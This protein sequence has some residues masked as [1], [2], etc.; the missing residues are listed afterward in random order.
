MLL[1]GERK[2]IKNSFVTL[3][4]IKKHSIKRVLFLCQ[5]FKNLNRD[6]SNMFHIKSFSSNQANKHTDFMRFK[7]KKTITKF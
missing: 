3:Y 6:L 2:Q 1:L 5:K 7:T 4:F